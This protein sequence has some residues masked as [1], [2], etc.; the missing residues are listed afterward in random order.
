MG[1]DNNNGQNKNWTLSFHGLLNIVHTFYLKSM[2]ILKSFKNSTNLDQA[3]ISS[4][5]CFEMTQD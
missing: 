1:K 4:L 2:G 5:S 3:E